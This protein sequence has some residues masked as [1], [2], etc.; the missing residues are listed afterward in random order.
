MVGRA[1][2]TLDRYTLTDKGGVIRGRCEPTPSNPP[3]RDS[4]GSSQRRFV[5]TYVGN[6]EHF[7]IAPWLPG[8]GTTCQR[9]SLG[10]MIEKVRS[11]AR[12]NLSR[13][14]ALFLASRDRVACE[15]F[16]PPRSSLKKSQR[17]HVLYPR[18][19]GQA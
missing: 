17:K 2:L 19:A 8:I 6:R 9:R 18:F 1:I 14:P 4:L 13:S 12:E 15:Q 3:S 11:C 10:L 5:G 7:R 16:Q